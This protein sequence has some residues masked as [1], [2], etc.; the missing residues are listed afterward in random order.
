MY[1]ES[2]LG[3]KISPRNCNYLK[4]LNR[5][6]V[7]PDVNLAFFF[8]NFKNCTFYSK[9]NSKLIQTKIILSLAL[10]F[11]KNNNKAKQIFIPNQWSDVRDPCG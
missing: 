2:R 11:L 8:W 1:L 4:I 9:E 10:T 5:L 7:L 6:Y 3:S